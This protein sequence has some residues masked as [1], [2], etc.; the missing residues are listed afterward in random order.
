MI[1]NEAA[2]RLLARRSSRYGASVGNHSARMSK[3][4]ST[5]PRLLMIKSISVIRVVRGG[6]RKGESE[7]ITRIRVGLN[8]EGQ[9]GWGQT[10]LWTALG[11]Q[12]SPSDDDPR[13][14]PSGLRGNP[15][16]T[17]GRWELRATVMVHCNRVS[18]RV[19]AEPARLW[20]HP[21]DAMAAA[22]APKAASG[23]L[24]GHSMIRRPVY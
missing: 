17:S 19:D 3:A 4:C 21:V 6:D 23:A 12:P 15:W 5:R 24:H 20:R 16:A 9:V 22:R 11:Q 8:I 18:P 7:D 2:R 14:A 13:R 1:E 10:C